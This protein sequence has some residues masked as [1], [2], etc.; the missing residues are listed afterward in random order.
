MAM[1][2]RAVAAAAV[3]LLAAAGGASAA[4]LALYNRCGETVWPG[5]QPS[6]GKELLARGG[7]QLLP[8]HAA[9]IRLPAGWSGRV[10]GRQGC[11]FDAAGRGRC[12]T[13]DCGGTL[14]CNGAGGAPPATLAEITLASA[15]AA[16]DFYDVSLVDGYNLPMVVEAAAPGCPVTGCLVDLN[17]RC[18]AELRAGQGPAQACRSAC[19]AFG[20]PEYC[21]SGDYGNPDTCRPSVYSQMFKTACPRSYSYAYDDATSTFTCTATDYS[22]TFCPPRAGTPNR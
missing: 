7:M 21:C 12:A 16:Q 15:P 8:G 20:R 4:T 2:M 22:I 1:A 14:Y 18:P 17:E 9:S 11:R 19:E 13:G 3:L 10:W 6:A 5:I